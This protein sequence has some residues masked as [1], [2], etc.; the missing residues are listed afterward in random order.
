M[1][2]PVTDIWELWDQDD[3]FEELHLSGSLE[4][5]LEATGEKKQLKRAEP[6]K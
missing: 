1:T 2:E 6:M 4:E 3:T 5:L